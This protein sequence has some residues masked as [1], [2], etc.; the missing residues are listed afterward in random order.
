MEERVIRVVNHACPHCG[1]VMDSVI[2][3][4]P[5]DNDKVPGVGDITLC[6]KCAAI[7]V[8]KPDLGVR[9]ITVKEMKEIVDGDTE[10]FDKLMRA[11]VAIMVINKKAE[12]SK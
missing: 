1:H 5:D 10:L 4:F 9:R 12:R 7:L 3:A 8:F 6:I 2:A 11:V